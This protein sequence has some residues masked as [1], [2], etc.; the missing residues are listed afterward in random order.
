MSTDTESLVPVEPSRNVRTIRGADLPDDAVALFGQTAMT[1]W[2]SFDTTTPEGILT[3]DK[4][5]TAEDAK[6]STLINC[7]LTIAN[8]YAHK[9]DYTTEG[10]EVVNL[11]RMC[12]ITPDGKVFGTCSGGIARSLLRLFKQ[13]RLPPWKPGVTV[14]VNQREARNRRWFDLTNVPKPN[15]ETP[16]RLRRTQ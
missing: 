16:V 6:L 2:A 15:G 7:E 11:T 1:A 12:L 10:G 8:V 9:V 3:L 13:H 4:C 14:K 5:E